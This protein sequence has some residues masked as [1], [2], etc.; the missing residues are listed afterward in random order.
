MWV[1]AS[2]V[3]GGGQ[4]AP[5]DFPPGNFWQLIGKNEAMKKGKKWEILRKIRKK[6]KKK[7]NEKY[8]VKMTGKS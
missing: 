5:R 8:K 7:E 2:G 4:G 1:L 6:L 3:T